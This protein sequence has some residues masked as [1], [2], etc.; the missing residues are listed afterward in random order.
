M[1]SIFL[2]QAHFMTIDIIHTPILLTLITMECHPT[3]IFIPRHLLGAVD[4]LCI[5]VTRIMDIILVFILRIPL[6]KLLQCMHTANVH[7]FQAEWWQFTC[8]PKQF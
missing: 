6:L 3:V 4:I 8:H 2:N 1:N 5:L 7:H